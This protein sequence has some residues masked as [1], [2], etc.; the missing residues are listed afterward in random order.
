MRR[1]RA[2]LRGSRGGRRTTA[3][4]PAGAEGGEAPPRFPHKGAGGCPHP[5][6]GATPQRR[7]LRQPHRGQGRSRSPPARIPGEPRELLTCAQLSPLGR[8]P[9]NS[10]RPPIGRAACLSVLPAR[11]LVAYV[12]HFSV[13][14]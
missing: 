5:A 10:Q 9:F 6:R 14:P 2:A 12:R 13:P 7:R 4:L 8:R 11:L 3:S 1:S